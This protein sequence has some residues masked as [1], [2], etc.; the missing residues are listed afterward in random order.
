MGYGILLFGV[1]LILFF[2]GIPLM[3]SILSTSTI[4][5]LVTQMKPLT[6]IPQKFIGQMDSFTFMAVPLFIFAGYLMERGGI[7]RRLVDWV[8]IPL[9]GFRGHL[10]AVAIVACAVFAALMGSGPATVAAIGGMLLTPMIQDG[11]PEEGAIGIVAAGSTLGPIIPPSIPMITYGV[12]MGVSIPMLFAGGIMPGILIMLTFLCVN[13][14][15]AKRK[16]KLEKRKNTATIKE[17][18]IATWK[19]AGVIAFPIVVLGGIYTGIFTPT[20]A[21]AVAV[22]MSIVLGFAYRDLTVG[23]IIE[24]MKKTIP[25]TALCTCIMGAAGSFTWIMSVTQLPTK[26]VDAVVPHLHSKA[27]YMLLLIV[28]LLIVGALMDTLT[29]IILLAPILVLVGEALG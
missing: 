8:K 27:L 14:Y 20:E 18:L 23:L 16:Y 17:W 12:T 3:F 10:G 28:I 1:L 7:S 9:G 26:F 22:A 11:Y 6:V 13:A 5:L 19:A 21:A 15:L 25:S 4:F 24:C 2:L 29:S